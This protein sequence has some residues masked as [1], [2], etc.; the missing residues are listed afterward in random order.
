METQTDDFNVFTSEKRATRSPRAM[1]EGLAQLKPIIYKTRRCEPKAP[2]PR[3]FDDKASN[4]HLL[5]KSLNM[6]VVRLP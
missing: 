2:S 6:I 4:L 5:E 1:M 3:A